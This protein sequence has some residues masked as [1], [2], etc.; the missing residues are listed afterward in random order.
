[1]SGAQENTACAPFPWKDAMA[2]GLGH[3]RL[4]ACDFWAMTPRELNAAYV[5]CFGESTPA[6]DR[7]SLAQL[8]QQ[9]PDK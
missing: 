3:L 9:F 4:G 2:F 8:M 5:G 6:C 7:Q 1:M